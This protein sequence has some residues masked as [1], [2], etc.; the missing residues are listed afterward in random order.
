MAVAVS[1][2]LAC[3]LSLALPAR[4]PAAGMITHAWMADEAIGH[5]SDPKLEAYL[6]LHNHEVLSGASS[7]DT[8]YAAGGY[9]EITHWER[10]VNAYVSYLRGRSGCGDLTSRL[11]PCAPLVAHMFGVAAHG[12]GDE[13]WDWLFEPLITDHGESPEFPV[14][15]PPPADAA[16]VI[17]SQEYAMDTIA[18]ADHFRWGESGYFLPPPNELT[19]I[20]DAANHGHTTEADILSGF[21]VGSAALTAERAGGVADAPRVREQMPW[22]SAHMDDESG[23][24]LFNARAI[25]GYYDALWE[26]LNSDDPPAPKVV[27]VHPE[28]GEENVPFQ[29]Q[30]AKTSPGLSTGGGE[31]RIVAVL[32]NAVDPL[33][34]DPTTFKLL[35]PAGEQVPALVDQA[36]PTAHHHEEETD[37]HRDESVPPL[38]GFPRVGPYGGSDG[39][40]T[41]MIYPAVDLEPCTTYTAQLTTGIKDMGDLAINE[42]DPLP[43]PVS[44]TFS[45]R[46]AGGEECPRIVPPVELPRCG[47]QEATVFAVRGDD[48]RLAGTAGPDVIVASRG[49]DTVRAGGGD[50]LVCLGGGDDRATGA[51]GADEIRA[52]GGDDNIRAGGGNDLVRGL[53]GTDRIRAGGGEDEIHGGA[54]DDVLRGAGGDDEL[55]GKSGDD[56]L[57]GGPGSDRCKGGTPGR[58]DRARSCERATGIP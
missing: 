45:T 13:M 56:R 51:A 18:L 54:G 2:T 26:K 12:M 39:T 6:D 16:N 22:S 37:A 10:F 44:W 24:V 7:P 1:L 27:S 5:V 23:G 21:A 33:S 52:G 4:A 11:S 15:F 53:S 8:G 19:P 50:D 29:F 20:Y 30:P 3:L 40:H 9:G 25:A 14:S 34:V 41:L 17:S 42:G 31:L 35:G 47:R 32:S 46:S 43:R 48:G 38:D 58:G 57:D 49:D 36:S 55:I 28:D